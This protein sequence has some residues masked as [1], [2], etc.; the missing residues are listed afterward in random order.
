M[1]LLSKSLQEEYEREAI[2]W[3][4]TEFVDNRPCLDVLEGNPGV[5]VILNEV[6]GRAVF[7]SN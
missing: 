4:F 1:T 2:P 7:C 6:K 5:F 3:T